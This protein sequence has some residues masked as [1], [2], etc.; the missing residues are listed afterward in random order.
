V[1]WVKCRK[2]SKSI[3]QGE[4]ADQ[5]IPM[6]DEDSNDNDANNGDQAARLDRL[7]G[8]LCLAPGTP[9]ALRYALSY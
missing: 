3:A 7:Q 6:N 5:V 8:Y 4:V 9:I 2:H 1:L